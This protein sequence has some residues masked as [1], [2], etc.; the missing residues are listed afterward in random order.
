VITCTYCGSSHEEDGTIFCKECGRRLPA[1]ADIR[2]LRLRIQELEA[3]VEGLKFG[4]NCRFSG[5]G[6]GDCENFVGLPGHSI[7][8]QHDGDDDTVDHYGKPNGWCW[9]C[10]L[11]HEQGRIQRELRE[12]QETLEQERVQH[13]GCLTAAEG[14]TS[15][16][17]VQG[18]YGWSL[19]YQRT[20]ELRLKHDMLEAGSKLSEHLNAIE[21]TLEGAAK[22]RSFWDVVGEDDD[23]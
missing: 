14:H 4:G 12:A 23:D 10:W 13:A 18:D 7:P 3:Q 17:A 15:N 8:G 1:T 21:E 19:A 20:L 9:H 6:R 5:P 11:M 22:P 16:P 2:R